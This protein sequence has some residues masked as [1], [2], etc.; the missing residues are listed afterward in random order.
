MNPAVTVGV[1]TRFKFGLRPSTRATFRLYKLVLYI[2]CQGVGAI[3]AAGV[4]CTLMYTNVVRP[5]GF[6]LPPNPSRYG[7][8]TAFCGELLGTFVLVLVVLNAATVKK[9]E[10]NSYFG[11]AIAAAIAAISTTLGPITGGCL[12]P[13]V[14]LLTAV[15]GAFPA[16]FSFAPLWVYFVA[17]PLGGFFAAIIFRVQNIDDY[18]EFYAA[19]VAKRYSVMTNGL[20]EE[21]KYHKQGRLNDAGEQVK[22]ASVATARASLNRASVQRGGAALP[23]SG[24]PPPITEQNSSRIISMS[25][26]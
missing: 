7:M 12:N 26:A 15:R 6:P 20:E 25:A 5:T 22:R 24:P 10:G 4:G 18:D 8:M 14:A 13:A 17:C 11:L 2:F 23:P 9:V 3:T 19:D 16:G 21:N 1:Y